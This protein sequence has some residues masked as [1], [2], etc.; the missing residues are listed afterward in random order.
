[1]AAGEP[2]AAGVGK[3][4]VDVVGKQAGTKAALPPAAK[5]EGEACARTVMRAVLA[6]LVAASAAYCCAFFLADETLW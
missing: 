6:R 5:G 4:D 2:A 3:V 1:M